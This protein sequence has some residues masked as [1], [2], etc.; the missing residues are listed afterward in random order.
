MPLREELIEPPDQ[1]L[2]FLVENERI[3]QQIT[4]PKNQVLLHP[5]NNLPAQRRILGAVVRWNGQDHFTA[6]RI[7]RGSPE[8]RGGVGNRFWSAP[9]AR[10]T[11]QR[12]RLRSSGERPNRC[13][14]NLI[15]DMTFASGCV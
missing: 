4:R 8:R 9:S 12:N 14:C 6:F 10:L 7:D 11:S 1:R 13:S 2:L 15:S 3:T 5:L